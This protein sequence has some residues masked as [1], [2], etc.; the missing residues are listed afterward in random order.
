MDDSIRRHDVSSDDLC[1]V[2][3]DAVRVTRQTELRILKRIDALRVRTNC[4]TTR[5]TIDHVIA[6]NI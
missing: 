1:L 2:D 5:D 6:Q 3:E 4:G